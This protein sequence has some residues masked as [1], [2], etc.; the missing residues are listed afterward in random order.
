MSDDAHGD[1]PTSTGQQPVGDLTHVRPDGSAH[2]VDVTGKAET[3]REAAAQAVLTTRPDVVARHGADVDLVLT[4]GGVSAGAYEV[5]RDAFEASGVVFGSVAMQPGGPQGHGTLTVGHRALPIVCFPGN[6]V[7]ALV[8]FEVFLRPLL[9]TATGVGRPRAQRAAPMA[10]SADSPVGKHQLRRG[11]LD[12]DG[13]VALVGGPGSHLLS[14]HAAAT[15]LVHV[16]V[17]VDRVE[18]GDEVV[19]WALDD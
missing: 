18:E 5:V 19:V 15:V 12:V 6:P 4:T 7:S 9:Q 11:R 1:Q 14:N 13:R 3:S 10:E 16:P 8:S 2:M 17:G